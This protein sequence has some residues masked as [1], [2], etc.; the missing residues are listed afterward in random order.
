MN[1]QQAFNYLATLGLGSV[2]TIIIK[3]VFDRKTQ[4]RKMLFETRTKAYVGITGRLFNLFQDPDIHQLADPLKYPK[5]NQIFSEVLLLGSHNLVKLVTEYKEIVVKFYEALSLHDADELKR[6]HSE[7]VKLTA[8]L[9][10]Q[11]RK[12]LGID[13]KSIFPKIADSQIYD[14]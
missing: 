12:D 5:L 8:L 14:D 9:H 13:R 2:I 1:F 4:E 10:T 6:L 7:L 11:M 3:A